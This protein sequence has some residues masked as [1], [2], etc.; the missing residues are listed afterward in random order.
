MFRCPSC[1]SRVAAQSPLFTFLS[2]LPQRSGVHVKCQNIR[3][4]RTERSVYVSSVRNLVCAIVGVSFSAPHP[5]PFHA[6]EIDIDDSKTVQQR[7]SPSTMLSSKDLVGRLAGLQDFWPF[8]GDPWIIAESVGEARPTL[9]Q[10]PSRFARC[11][12]PSHFAQCLQPRPPVVR[13]PTLAHSRPGWQRSVCAVILEKKPTK[14]SSLQSTQKCFAC[15]VCN[16]QEKVDLK[17]PFVW[18]HMEQP[19]VKAMYERKRE[20]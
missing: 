4:R 16:P 10:K 17:T 5:K 20:G 19:R 18:L 11:H 14:Y 12:H 7:F 13:A 15:S 3:V 1:T 8:R 6:R 9:L 2:R